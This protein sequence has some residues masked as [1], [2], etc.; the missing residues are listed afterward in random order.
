MPGSSAAV[1]CAVANFDCYSSHPFFRFPATL[2]LFTLPGR[3]SDLLRPLFWSGGGRCFPV[4][5][6]VLSASENGYFG[7]Y[8]QVG[9]LH[10]HRMAI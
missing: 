7:W 4:I 5:P 3:T 10:T 6:V 8:L 9:G 2:S 1:G